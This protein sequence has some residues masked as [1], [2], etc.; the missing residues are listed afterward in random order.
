M[1]ASLGI[2]R[3]LVMLRG[4]FSLWKG[5]LNFWPGIPEVSFPERRQEHNKIFGGKVPSGK[6]KA[7]A[8]K[9]GKLR[10]ARGKL[11]VTS[12]KDS[13][14]ELRPGPSPWVARLSLLPGEYQKEM[15]GGDPMTWQS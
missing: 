1:T 4:S 12:H 7:S 11:V 10:P 2:K 9:V 6:D 3:E 13:E 5:R 14:A 15:E 8:T